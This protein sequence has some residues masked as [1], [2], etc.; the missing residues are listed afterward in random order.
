MGAAGEKVGGGYGLEGVAVGFQE[1][2]V[3]GQGGGV[4][5]DVDDALRGHGD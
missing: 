1:G 5:G 4:A 3:P 2:Y